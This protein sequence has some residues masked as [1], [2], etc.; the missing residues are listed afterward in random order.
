M[1]FWVAVV[2]VHDGIGTRNGVLLWASSGTDLQALGAELLFGK[3][4]DSCF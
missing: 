2:G 4:I 3:L 1:V